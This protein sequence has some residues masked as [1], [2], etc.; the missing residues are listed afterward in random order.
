VRRAMAIGIAMMMAGCAGSCRHEAASSGAAPPAPPSDGAPALAER[1][2]ALR[3]GGRHNVEYVPPGRD[4]EK[5]YGQW[6]LAV[7]RAAIAGETPTAAPPPGFVLERVHDL[8][9]LAEAPDRRR[10]AGAVAVR[11]GAA[12]PVLVEAP[13][14]FFDM[15][16]LP[17]ALAA[18]D[19]GRCRALLVNTVYRYASGEPV[20]G[21][22]DGAVHAASDVAH[23]P[24]SFFLA[25]HRALLGLE[26]RPAAVQLHGFADQR[27]HGAD[28]ILSASATT[29]PLDA[30]GARLRSVLGDAVRL[31]PAEV[32]VLGGLTN[33]QAAASRDAGAPFLHV[34]MSRT[35]RDRLTADEALRRRAGA[36]LVLTPAP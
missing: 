5:E 19:A 31:F 28:V 25:A 8:W 22:D 35:L 2:E 36:A 34:E 30:A 4:E 16:T 18:F 26:P 27:A 11:I 14:T 23:A 6:L 3:K 17:V 21:D 33:V 24:S 7:A 32:S 20:G 29:A 1:L 12:A 15:G 13:H 10:G 9:L